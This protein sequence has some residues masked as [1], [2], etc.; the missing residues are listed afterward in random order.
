MHVIDVIRQAAL[1]PEG[2][3]GHVGERAPDE[4]YGKIV[5]IVLLSAPVPELDVA[6]VPLVVLQLVDRVQVQL[7][8]AHVLVQ[9]HA[10]VLLP[11]VVELGSATL[12]I[13]HSSQHSTAHFQLAPQSAA[14]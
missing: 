9:P 8:L 2:Q 12:S 4:T 7:H 14:Q 3:P 13:S 6:L 11:Q 10:L 1:R 5:I